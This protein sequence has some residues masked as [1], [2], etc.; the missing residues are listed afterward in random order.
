[1]EPHL[2]DSWS[3]DAISNDRSTS[4]RVSRNRHSSAFR[5]CGMAVLGDTDHESSYNS[6]RRHRVEGSYDSG[7][8]IIAKST[9]LAQP[10]ATPTAMARY[11]RAGIPVIRI[12]TS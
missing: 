7:G 10:V 11:L 12:E 2:L 9:S 6:A 4:P 3:R 1:M 8:M 5:P